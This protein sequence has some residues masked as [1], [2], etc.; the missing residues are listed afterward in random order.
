M[1][2]R[3]CACTHTHTHTT[4]FEYEDHFDLKMKHTT[5]KPNCFNQEADVTYSLKGC[6]MKLVKMK[7]ISK[8]A[9]KNSDNN[10]N[11][12]CI[13]EVLNPSVVHVW[14]SKCCT[15]NITTAHNLLNN[16]LPISLYPSLPRMQTCASISQ[17][18]MHTC[19]FLSLPV[20]HVLLFLSFSISTPPNNHQSVKTSAT[21]TSPCQ[22]SLSLR[23]SFGLCCEL[24]LS[25]LCQWV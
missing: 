8:Y 12:K 25:L 13:S 4:T 24:P 20:S 16:A 3:T 11:N 17:S 22:F 2:A 18:F 5:T 6:C 19:A 15:W 10:N 7:L 23:T 1:H 14:G 21:T 9:Y